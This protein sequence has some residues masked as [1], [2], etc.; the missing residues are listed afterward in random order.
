MA[1]VAVVQQQTAAPSDNS[2]SN[3]KIKIA[4]GALIFSNEKNIIFVPSTNTEI[5]FYMLALN[6][7]ISSED[8]DFIR[9]L[10]AKADELY[11]SKKG[12]N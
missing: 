5:N 3:R 10:R 1:H 4:D 2:M 7:L 12:D 8:Q 6:D 9:L 11:N